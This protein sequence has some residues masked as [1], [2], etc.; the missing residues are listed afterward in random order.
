MY[1]TEDRSYFDSVLGKVLQAQ[2]TIEAFLGGGG[3]MTLK[4]VAHWPIGDRNCQRHGNRSG[5]KWRHNVIYFMTLDLAECH[6]NR[7]GHCFVKTN[8]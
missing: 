2:K 7:K 6:L 1:F 8:H 3:Q 5:N 4:V